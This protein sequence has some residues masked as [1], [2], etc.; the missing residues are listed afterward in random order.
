MEWYSVVLKE[1]IEKRYQQ[2]EGQKM[3]ETN[4]FVAITQVVSARIGIIDANYQTGIR[5]AQIWCQA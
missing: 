1:L 5:R 4:W 2:E 3:L